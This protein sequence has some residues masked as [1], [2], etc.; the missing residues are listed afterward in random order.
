MVAGN[1]QGG[2]TLYHAVLQAAFHLQVAQVLKQVIGYLFIYICAYLGFQFPDQLFAVD[3]QGI[4]I[5]EDGIPV[6]NRS[7][8]VGGRTT[9]HAIVNSLKVDMERAEQFKRD[10]GFALDVQNGIPQTIESS[11]SP[12]VNEIKYGLD[13]YY[14]HPTSRK[15][16]RIILTGGSAYLPRLPEYLTSLLSMKVFVGDPWAR[17]IYPVELK[18]ALDEIAPR[19]AGAVGLGM[20][21]II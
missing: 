12:V 5:A 13:L 4:I 7:V 6:L 8:D 2:G 15:V 1:V 10:I 11:V 20:R 21:E 14:S 3:V 16:E 19:F 17:V 9:T 18:P